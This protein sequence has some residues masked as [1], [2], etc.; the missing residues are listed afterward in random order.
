[1][2]GPRSIYGMSNTPDMT[3]FSFRLDRD[4]M[5]ANKMRDIMLTYIRCQS[6]RNEVPS[7]FRSGDEISMEL[8]GEHVRAMVLFDPQR[9]EVRMSAPAAITTGQ[10]IMVSQRLLRYRPNL[11]LTQMA[12]DEPAATTECIRKAWEHLEELYCDYRIAYSIRDTLRT[13]YVRYQREEQEIREREKELNRP[14]L[15]EIEVLRKE[16][17]LLKKRF[18]EG[19]LPE[20]EYKKERRRLIDMIDA[21]Q[22]LLSNEDV[23]GRIF[24][25]EILLLRSV[26]SGR[27]LIRDIAEEKI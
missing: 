18:K 1:M 14:I 25:D 27:K 5:R 10:D 11:S 24:H 16:K 13:K 20:L 6:V 12:E 7:P 26:N 19:L 21:K 23:F 3:P 4:L 8:Q 17:S 2:P 15:E 22:A 9:I